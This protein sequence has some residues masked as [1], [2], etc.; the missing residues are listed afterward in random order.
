M[1]RASAAAR[2]EALEAEIAALRQQQQQQRRAADATAGGVVVGGV[3]FSS[4]SS[5]AADTAAL[6]ALSARFQ[7]LRVELDG[8]QADVERML[9]DRR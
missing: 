3:S 5:A 2:T 8:A 1:A 7:R 6:R 9:A 4:S